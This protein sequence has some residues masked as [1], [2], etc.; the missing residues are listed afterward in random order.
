MER[1]GEIGQLS[2]YDVYLTFSH[3]FERFA[4]QEVS[5][6]NGHFTHYSKN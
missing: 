6:Q 3:P 2:F 1:T 5:G 4:Y